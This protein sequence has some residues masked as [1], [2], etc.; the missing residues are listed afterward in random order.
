M[1]DYDGTVPATASQV[2]AALKD[3][4]IDALVELAKTLQEKAGDKEFVES[5]LVLIY[6]LLPTSAREQILKDGAAASA[7]IID[8]FTREPRG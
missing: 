7:N 5:M 6:E 1:S 2:A 8:L 3:G 4:D